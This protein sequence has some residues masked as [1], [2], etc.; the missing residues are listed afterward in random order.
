MKI[1]TIFLIFTSMTLFQH[2]LFA[3]QKEANTILLE[4]AIEMALKNQ[5]LLKEAEEQINSADAKIKQQKSF[6]YPNVEA[7]LSYSRIGP[8]P[9]FDFGGNKIYLAPDNNYDAHVSARELLYDFGKRDALVELSK[10]YKLSSKD[11][12]DLI[13]S[14]LAYQTI[15][16][17]YSI[18]FFQ[19]AIEVKNEQIN[20]LNKH[21]EITAK[22]VESGSATDYDILTTKVKLAAVQNQKTD[23]KNA[24]ENSKI[25]LKSLMGISDQREIIVSGNFTADTSMFNVDSLVARAFSQR[26]EIILAKD[27]EKSAS[28][29]KDLISTSENPMLNLFVSMGFKNGYV[30]DLNKIRGNWAVGVNAKIP[31]FNGNLKDHK[32]EEA[33]ANIRSASAEILELERKIKTEIQKSVADYNSNLAK[34]KT[35]ELQVEQ[36]KQAVDRAEIR[37]RD[38]VITN[39]DLIDA[40]TSL[41]EAEL[42]Y[43]QVL[44]SNVLKYYEVSK[45][46]G[47]KVW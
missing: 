39:L 43:V 23:M 34:F 13:K 45:A 35:T 19:R 27:H 9:T 32:I 14:N 30:P 25:Y 41:S 21:I 7:D 38:G 31:I 47:N 28:L 17:F 4:K 22:R 15:K 10:S 2:N 12:I 5:P 1:K 6:Y 44:Y 11:K 3:Q 20:N 29:N 46:I 26:S 24:L 37:Y 36:A 42:Q 16:A 18:L 33:E 8:V 40:E